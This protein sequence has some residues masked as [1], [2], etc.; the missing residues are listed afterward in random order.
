MLNFDSPL[1]LIL[2]LLSGYLFLISFYFSRYYHSKIETQRLIFNSMLCALFIYFVSYYF[3][4]KI[5][6]YYPHFRNNL[7]KLNPFVFQ[8]L[9]FGLLTL[10]VSLILSYFLNF[11]I[12]TKWMLKITVRLWGDEYER[13]FYKSMNEKKIEDG[14]LTITTE[15]GKVYVGYVNRISKPLINQ[16]IEIIPYMSGY[17]E[18]ET[19]V[20]HLTTFYFDIL[21]YFIENGQKEKIDDEMGIILPKDKIVSASRFSLEVFN[22]FS[23]QNMPKKKNKQKNK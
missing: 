5:L 12:P 20:L 8:S 18:D 9:N 21:E 22:M 14:L 16:Q 15:S 19:K 4:L 10:G 7:K 2:P 13:L 17:R 1:L 3:D 23:I 6:Q 11:V